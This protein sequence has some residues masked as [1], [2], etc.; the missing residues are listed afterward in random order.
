MKKDSRKSNAVKYL[1]TVIIHWLNPIT[2]ILRKD[3]RGEVQIKFSLNLK[4]KW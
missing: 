3:F 2:D 1:H 4:N